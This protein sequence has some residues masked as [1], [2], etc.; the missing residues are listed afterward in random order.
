[1]QRL[2]KFTPV[3]YLFNN[4]MQVNCTCI[5]DYKTCLNFLIEGK[6]EHFGGNLR[7]D[8]HGEPKRDQEGD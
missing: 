8:P 4:M 6:I 1:M 7:V 5:E 2:C 3:S